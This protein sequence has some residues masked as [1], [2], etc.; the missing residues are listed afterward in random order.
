MP[1]RVIAYLA[2]FFTLALPLRLSAEV[3][4]IGVLSSQGFHTSMK[5]W[6]GTA[7]YLTTSIP[8][9][10]F[11]IL[12]YSRYAD[13]ETDMNKN[14]LDFLLAAKHELSRF[15]ADF[16][17]MPLMNSMTGKYNNEWTLTRKRQLPY[18]LTFSVSEA[19]LKL[20]ARHNAMK[21]SGLTSWQL[22]A[23]A[24]VAISSEQKLK[25]LYN[26]ST[27]LALMAVKQY[28]T[29]I[30]AILVSGLLILLYRK[31]DLYHSRQA[32]VKAHRQQSNDPSLSDTVF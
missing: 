6:Q 12:P 5:Q 23:D 20:P 3:V 18:Q 24:H 4:K 30:L 31:W 13:L 22:S 9:H 29:F 16:S 21:R 28:W 25:K 17:V 11:Q 32:K 10:V 27:E 15:V 7:N 14:K 2:V 8:G 26:T 19:L 1:F